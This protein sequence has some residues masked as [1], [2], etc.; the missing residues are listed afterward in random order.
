MH[1]CRDD[2]M[3]RSLDAVVRKFTASSILFF[4]HYFDLLLG[5]V[6]M[7]ATYILLINQFD[8][9]YVLRKNPDQVGGRPIWQSEQTGRGSHA[10]VEIAR[11]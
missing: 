3:I 10:P 4:L 7:I 8:A 6:V 2:F 1:A 5:N 9:F 11:R